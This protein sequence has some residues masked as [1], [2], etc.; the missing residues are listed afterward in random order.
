MIKPPASFYVSSQ[1]LLFLICCDEKP[2][3][4]AGGWPHQRWSNNETFTVNVGRIRSVGSA[5][6]S[7]R[8]SPYSTERIANHC[9]KRV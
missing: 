3:P 7:Y 5:N 1:R 6:F 9:R 2:F 4:F 8:I